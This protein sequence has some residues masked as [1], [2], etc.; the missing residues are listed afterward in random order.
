MSAFIVNDA[1]I[2]YLAAFAQDRC[3]KLRPEGPAASLEV[4]AHNAASGYNEPGGYYRLDDDPVRIWALL[5]AENVKSVNYRYGKDTP[6]VRYQY[7]RPTV[8]LAAAR[9]IQ[10][11]RCL[12]Y[13]SCEHPGYYDSLAYQV[14]KKIEA[15]AVAEIV[16]PHL[17]DEPW[18]L[19]SEHVYGERGIAGKTFTK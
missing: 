14:L 16:N 1:H 7:R 10:A 19:S 5:Y 18:E 11:C 6:L 15:E 9:A 8:P 13:Q 17:K 4:S 3:L 12:R 2:S